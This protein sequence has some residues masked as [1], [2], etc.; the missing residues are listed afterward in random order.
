[1]TGGEPL[2]TSVTIET[3]SLTSPQGQEEGSDPKD[4]QPSSPVEMMPF[5]RM[6]EQSLTTRL[7][8][9]RP[10]TAEVAC[11]QASPSS[12]SEEINYLGSDVDWDNMHSAPDSSKFSHLAVEKMEVISVEGNL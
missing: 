12:L 9:I 8:A 1:M 7:M 11:T 10:L 3:I 2:P 5:M 4:M 6:P